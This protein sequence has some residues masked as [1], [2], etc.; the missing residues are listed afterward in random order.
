MTRRDLIDRIET[1]VMIYSSNRDPLP[2]AA[3][4]VGAIAREQAERDF[5]AGLF[6]NVLAMQLVPEISNT[7]AADALVTAIQLARAGDASTLP[8]VER[9]LR[10]VWAALRKIPQ[11]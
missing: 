11:A 5:A 2:P 6:Q 8:T 1:W 10:D 3:T 9:L 7:P 4:P